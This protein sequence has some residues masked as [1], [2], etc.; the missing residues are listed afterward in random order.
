MIK[1]SNCN[2]SIFITNVLKP[3]YDK[4]NLLLFIYSKFSLF[5][6]NKNNMIMKHIKI[7]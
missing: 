3:N 1:M 6:D 5:I 2:H 7:L 4:T